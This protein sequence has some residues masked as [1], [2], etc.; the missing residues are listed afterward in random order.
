MCGGE[1]GGS[2]GGGGGGGVEQAKQHQTKSRDSH[3]V[4][5]FI[6]VIHYA[7][8]YITY[9]A[10]MSLK[11]AGSVTASF[12]NLARVALENSTNQTADVMFIA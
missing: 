3:S 5:N 6:I 9:L 7:S 10:V 11:S 12:K 1:G 8:H 2:G 4:K